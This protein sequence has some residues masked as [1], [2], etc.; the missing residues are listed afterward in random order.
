MVSVCIS[1]MTRYQCPFI[2][3]LAIC[4]STPGKGTAAD[5][6]LVDMQGFCVHSEDLSGMTSVPQHLLPLWALSFHALND[7]F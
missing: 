3:L 4:R 1:L 5:E 6:A 2:C 7:I